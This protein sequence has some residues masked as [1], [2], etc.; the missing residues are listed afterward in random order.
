MQIAIYCF[1]KAHDSYVAEG[2]QLFTKRISHYYPIMWYIIPVPKAA[3]TL[4]GAPYASAEGE[5]LLPKLLPTDYVVA[6]DERGE[7]LASPQLGSTI[8]KAANLSSKRLV[9]IIGGSYGLCNA[10][11]SKAN[12]LLSLSKLV[13]PHQLVRIILAEQLYRACT[14]NNNEKYHH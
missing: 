12:L 8:Q 1:G 2:V 4:N 6:L 14:I 10:V 11:K 7:M 3:A 9:L 13:F 5:I